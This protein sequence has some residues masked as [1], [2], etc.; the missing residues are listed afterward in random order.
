[1]KTEETR[2]QM[3]SGSE[4][5]AA[6]WRES[7]TGAVIKLKKGKKSHQRIFF[8]F[9]L[10]FSA[11]GRCGLAGRSQNN[12]LLPLTASGGAV[13]DRRRQKNARRRFQNKSER[14]RSWTGSR[15][16]CRGS[17]MAP[18]PA[19]VTSQVSSQMLP[20]AQQIF[21]FSRQTAAS[22]GRN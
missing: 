12:V 4:H 5:K 8:F 20:S 14:K 19:L 1:M 3:E 18:T 10:S 13:N 2:C 7:K 15:G 17:H 22:P 11:A 9:F 6:A 16:R 21:H